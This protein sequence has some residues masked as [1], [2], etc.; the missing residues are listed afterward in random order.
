MMGKEMLKI[1]YSAQEHHATVELPG[2]SC[3]CF[4]I[5]ESLKKHKDFLCFRFLLFHCTVNKGF[6]ILTV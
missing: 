6:Q 5:V 4:C 1:V 3:K 2:L